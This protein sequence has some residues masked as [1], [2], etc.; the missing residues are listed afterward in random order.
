MCVCVCN[1]LHDLVIPLILIGQYSSLVHNT[2][3]TGNTPPSLNCP[4]HANQ[5]IV[6]TS[7][8]EIQISPL[9][10]MSSV[11]CVFTA[12]HLAC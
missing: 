10:T 8:G 4:F 11:C 2:C 1:E 12:D 3:Q 9:F 5:Q 6:D 7:I